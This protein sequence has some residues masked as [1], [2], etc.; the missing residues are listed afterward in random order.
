MKVNDQ[1]LREASMPMH[2]TNLSKLNTT[3]ETGYLIFG[4]KKTYQFKARIKLILELS[5]GY[6]Y[7]LSDFLYSGHRA[8]RINATVIRLKVCVE[9]VLKRDARQTQANNA[10]LNENVRETLWKLK[11]TKN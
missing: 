10:A 4:T 3:T 1:S 7:T 6:S 11:K 2:K 8:N 5:Y 9:L